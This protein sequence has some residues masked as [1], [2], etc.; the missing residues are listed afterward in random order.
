MKSLAI[1]LARQPVAYRPGETLEGRVAWRNARILS[2]A[3]V[4]LVWRTAGKGTAYAGI[5]ALLKLKDPR[6]DDDRPFAF[7][8][9]THPCSFSCRLISLFWCV[10]VTLARGTFAWTPGSSHTLAVAS[11]Q[12]GFVGTRYAFGSWSDGGAQSHTIVVPESGDTYT[13]NFGT[14]YR[15]SV[16]R[17]GPGSPGPSAACAPGP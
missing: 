13:A 11:P 2:P 12:D 17:P 4:R 8:L 7:A 9:P 10:E 16:G 15:L 6:R 5:V 1:T 3:T 14:Q